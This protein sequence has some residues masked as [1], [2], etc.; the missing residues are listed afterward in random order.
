MTTAEAA[1]AL[2][3]SHSRVLHLIRDKRI[4]STIKIDTYGNPYHEIDAAELE[5]FQAIPRKRGRPAKTE[6]RP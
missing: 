1:K 5:R 2:G 6:P 4:V 3:I